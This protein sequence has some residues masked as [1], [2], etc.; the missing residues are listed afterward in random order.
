[1][2]RPSRDTPIIIR[3]KKIMGHGHHGGAW[4]V[5]FA[6]FMT[7]MFALFLVLWLVNQSADV[8]DAIAN[9]FRDPIGFE[10]GGNLQLSLGGAD[11]PR[12]DRQ[13]HDAIAVQRRRATLGSAGERIRQA[14]AASPALARLAR[15][16]EVE[17]TPEGLRIALTE[18]DGAHFFDSGS[19]RLEHRAE[20]VLE[21]VA[22]E[23]APLANAVLVEGHTDARPLHRG[24]G[25]SNWELSTDR[26]HQAR[27]MLVASGLDERRIAQVRGFADRDLLERDAPMSPRNRR[28]TITVLDEMASAHGGPADAT[29]TPTAATPSAAT[30]TATAHGATPPAV[31]PPA[32]PSA[33]AP[34]AATP[35]A[36]T[37]SAAAP[38]AAAPSAAVP[39]AGTPS[40]ATPPA[41]A[42][43]A[44]PSA[45]AH[46]D[47]RP[48]HSGKRAAAAAHGGAT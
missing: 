21:V 9:Y 37:P 15:N 12:A 7:A 48:S 43:A 23:L 30:P 47:E 22:H 24:D 26:A 41:V 32:A 45:A 1:M 19:A 6:D 36:A 27:R 29:A 35:S 25:Y 11:S 8:K 33:A 20:Q 42:P 16:V 38:A 3:K 4:K 34:S 17:M 46:A 28:I 2:A 40:A 14:L 13:V 18:D 5:A 10:Q 44:T 39:N 31:T